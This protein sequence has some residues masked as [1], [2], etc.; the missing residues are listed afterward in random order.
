MVWRAAAHYFAWVFGAGFALGMIRVPLLVPRL[1]VRAAELLELPVMLAMIAWAARR[2]TRSDTP[3]TA[4]RQLGLGG[5]AWAMLLAAEIGLGMALTGRDPL[6]VVLAH[7]PVSGACYYA[8]TVWFALAPWWWQ[9]RQ[10]SAIAVAATPAT[11]HTP[12]TTPVT[13]PSRNTFVNATPSG[14]GA[15]SASS[16]GVRSSSPSGRPQ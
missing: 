9:R 13:R 14:S 8:A 16:S 4:R 10:A 2:T 3:V 11:A 15:S 5:I 7:D 1:G 12:T 6:T